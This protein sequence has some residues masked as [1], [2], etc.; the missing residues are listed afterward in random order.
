[1][2]RYTVLSLIGAV[3][4]AALVTL[5]VMLLSSSPVFAG[6]DLVK[7]GQY[8]VE[9]TG[10]NDCHTPG[11][12]EKGG[13]V[14]KSEWLKGNP[15]GF[16]GPWGITFPV[17]LRLLINSMTED[18]WVAKAQTF[19]ARPPMPWFNVRF[20]RERDQR[21]LYQF[22][23]SLGP[24]GEPAPDYIPPGKL[25]KNKFIPFVPTSFKQ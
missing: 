22:I 14:P 3:N 15:V 2:K 21:A 17:N 1:M 6:E 4:I 12:A 8:I 11:Y 5:A 9:I 13:Q 23:K 19:Q 24:A 20:M 18:E 16:K 10:C 7:R 25:T